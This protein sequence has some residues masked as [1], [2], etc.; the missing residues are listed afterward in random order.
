MRIAKWVNSLAVRLPSVLCRQLNLKLGD[1]IALIATT[2][3]RIFEIM[4]Y[5][6]SAHILSE[7]RGF[8]GRLEHHERLT[9]EEANDRQGSTQ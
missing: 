4:P 7:L 6:S 2:D 1:N 3:Q 5:T 9:C 8:R